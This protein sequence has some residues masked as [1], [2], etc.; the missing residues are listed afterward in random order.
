M[1]EG[2]KK[3]L[4]RNDSDFPDEKYSVEDAAAHVESFYNKF[5]EIVGQNSDYISESVID[6]MRLAVQ[7][8]TRIKEL[9][10]TNSLLI[11]RLDKLEAINSLLIERL[12]KLEAQG[13]L[14]QDKV[15]HEDNPTEVEK[16]QMLLNGWSQALNKLENENM[17]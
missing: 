8:N 13:T 7:Q 12:D 11:E 14:E 5:K 16:L 17:Y 9:S 1:L 6:I 3:F 10:A 2:L 4:I 15:S